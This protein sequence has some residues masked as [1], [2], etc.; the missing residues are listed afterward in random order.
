MSDVSG[1]VAATP[2]LTDLG[3]A[4]NQK[5]PAIARRNAARQ[6][7]IS[8]S[9]VI[10]P[11]QSSTARPWAASA[12]SL[13]HRVAVRRGT[14]PRRPPATISAE[15]SRPTMSPTPTSASDRPVTATRAAPSTVHP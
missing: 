5:F 10:S 9:P 1:C 13:P 15:S 7:P 12:A 8:T 14:A 4:E 11:A 6:T 3:V 2:H